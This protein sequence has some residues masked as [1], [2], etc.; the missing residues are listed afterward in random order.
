MLEETIEDRARDGSI[1]EDFCHASKPRRGESPE[2]FQINRRPR[3]PVEAV[4][5]SCEMERAPFWMRIVWCL[6]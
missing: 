4:E 5:R 3:F 6:S 2:H 1:A